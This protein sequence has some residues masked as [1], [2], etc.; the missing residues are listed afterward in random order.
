MQMAIQGGAINGIYQTFGITNQ[1]NDRPR[2]ISA[3]Q[4]E[5]KDD[6]PR[7]VRGSDRKNVSFSNCG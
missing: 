3:R 6:Y 1:K 4:R 7:D 2:D 5:G